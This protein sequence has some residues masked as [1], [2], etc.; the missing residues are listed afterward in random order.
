MARKQYTAKKEGSK[1]HKKHK[2]T[3]AQHS[4]ERIIKTRAKYTIYTHVQKNYL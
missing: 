4:K 2:L 1:E 3:R